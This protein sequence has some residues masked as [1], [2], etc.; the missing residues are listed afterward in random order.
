MSSEV[1]T[2]S[3]PPRCGL[4]EPPSR[5]WLSGVASPV[6]P[7]D[8][9]LRVRLV[10]NCVLRRTPPPV[11]RVSG[12]R[13][14]VGHVQS[15]SRRRDGRPLRLTASGLI[16]ASIGAARPPSHA[17]GVCWCR[18]R[19][20]RR[21]VGTFGLGLTAE[22]GHRPETRRRSCI[23]ACSPSAS[24]CSVSPPSA[25]SMQRAVPSVPQSGR[26]RQASPQSVCYAAC[27]A[28]WLRDWFSD[29]IR[30]GPVATVN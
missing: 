30:D 3:T 12:A 17:T 4:S 11:A 2:S 8:W 9:H 25:S 13:A 15:D 10:H 7:A 21:D 26:R 28:S 16:C 24:G 20:R 14:R 23:T 19:P 22:L 6:P 5:R 18:Q 1:T 27:P 29:P